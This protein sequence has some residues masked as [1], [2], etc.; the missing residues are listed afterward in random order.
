MA[1]QTFFSFHYARDIFRVNTVRNAYA[2]RRLAHQ[3]L[4]DHSL[5][6]RTKLSGDAALRTLIDGGLRGAS[7]TVVLVGHETYGRRWV[8]YE[9]KESV[10]R[11]MGLL[12]IDITKIRDV[13]GQTDPPGPNPFSHLGITDYDGRPVRM[14]RTAG[15][16]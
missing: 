7:V 16:G 12:G 15:S 4:F 13:R 14:Y 2:F 3:G 5:W 9:I 6:E 8:Q 10:D 11:G 1:R